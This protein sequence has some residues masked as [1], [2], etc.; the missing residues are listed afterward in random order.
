[1]PL[2]RG[3]RFEMARYFHAGLIVFLTLSACASLTPKR[4]VVSNVFYATSPKITLRVDTDLTYIGGI[5]KS[6]GHPERDGPATITAT[7]EVYGFIAAEN[8]R[9]QRAVAVIIE[10]IRD[11][12]GF[13]YPELFTSAKNK[14]EHGVTPLG[15]KNFQYCTQILGLSSRHILAKLIAE[16]GYILPNC[17]MLKRFGRITGSRADTL[18]VLFYVEALPENDYSCVQWRDGVAAKREQLRDF[19]K[20]CQTTFEILK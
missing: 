9:V 5:K 7:R 11:V 10:R 3:L 2:L 20:N 17:T 8:H 4:E 19:N 18:I 15:G 16:K 14:L 6:S 1:M 12:G 13:Y